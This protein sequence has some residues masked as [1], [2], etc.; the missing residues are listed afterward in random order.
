M[1]AF[2]PQE[3]LG[4]LGS[5]TRTHFTYDFSLGKHEVTQQEFERV[6][7]YN[8]VPSG[9]LQNPDFPVVLIS[10]FEAVLFCN[11][12]SI[13]HGLD[14]VYQ[15]SGLS[16]DALGKVVSLEG[17]T[18]NYSATGFRLPTE[19][20]WEY[21]SQGNI[22]PW[23]TDE[24]K[25]SQYAW[26]LDNSQG[27]LHATC[28]LSPTQ[29]MC[30]L[31]GNAMEWVDGWYGELSNDTLENYIGAASPNSSLARIVK[32]GSFRSDLQGIQ[33]TQRADVYG[34]YSTTATEYLGFR[35]AQGVIPS[36]TF[37]SGDRIVA[38]SSSLR[39]SVTT[40]QVKAFF[41]TSNVKLAL[42]D[43][44]NDALVAIDFSSKELAIQT[45]SYATPVR[46]PTFS[47]DGKWLAF[48]NRSE[49]QSGPAQGFYV[50][51]N[52]LT[53]PLAI[54]RSSVA[55]P[56]WRVD[57]LTGDTVLLFSN[58]ASS[59]RDSLTWAS[60][61]TLQMT[62]KGNQFQASATVVS[63]QGSFHDG[64]SDDGRFLIT[65]YT[66][67]RVLDQQN[68]TI[69][70]LFKSPANGKDT[71]A[72]TQ[73]CNASIRVGA[74]PEIL[75]IDFGYDK[76]STLIGKPYAVHE[77]LFFMDPAS[78]NVTDWLG[79]PF[80][81]Q[82][83]DFPEW[84]N[85]SDFAVATVVNSNDKHVAIYA[86][87]RSDKAMLK[88]LEGADVWSPQLWI[89][90]AAYLGMDTNM[91]RYDIPATHYS[92]EFSSK[93]MLYW[94][95]HDSIDVAI[96]G[97]SRSNSGVNPTYFQNHRGLNMA[98]SSEDQWTGFNIWEAYLK[99]HSPALKWVVL[100]LNLDFLYFKS[101]ERWEPMWSNTYGYQYDKS[102]NFYSAGL[103]TQFSEM[104]KAAE[105]PVLAGTFTPQGFL[106]T[107][108]SGWGATLSRADLGLMGPH[109]DS[110]KQT[111]DSL[112][113]I[114]QEMDAKGIRV[115]GLLTPQSPKYSD[116]A[117]GTP[118][119]GR[120]GPSLDQ[121]VIMLDSLSAIQSRHVNFRIFDQ[122]L[123][124]KHDY[125]DDDAQNWDH[126]ASLGAVKMSTRIDS[127]MRAWN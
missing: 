104:V 13:S 100:E 120:Y 61:N 127:V 118:S 56:R 111:L 31:S 70:T 34:T 114:L 82:N 126:L 2:S 16:K 60:Q 66:D 21:A 99:N 9:S 23:G 88:L 108:S 96:L 79:V 17:V 78:G 39:L 18:A 37:L 48:A 3:N 64:M 25:A 87:R 41:H 112:E 35:I 4:H 63:T 91:F 106:S 117:F 113:G 73:V 122:H 7:G 6:M 53:K 45:A 10:W 12:A 97:S 107:T 94:A 32:G 109:P 67:L 49:G 36:P 14:T 101:V 65:S 29:E 26:F 20:E 77:Y 95:V 11:Q 46:L 42:V 15:Y 44:T 71:S 57:E 84:S 52:N 125:T 47:P 102:Q 8:P 51:W 69:R 62:W 98:M 38:A 24:T 105:T 40:E 68:N 1:V 72:S 86:I 75:F 81:Y 110:W 85:H 54:D 43:A 124:G 116:P 58:E 103:P 22:Y 90:N 30:D 83:W 89:S 119:W 80:P 55:V 28:S 92:I 33:S 59:N 50:A 74:S 93:M 115:I 5:Q 76:S 123:L 121:A 19:A 27:T